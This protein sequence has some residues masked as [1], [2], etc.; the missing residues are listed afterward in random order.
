VNDETVVYP[1]LYRY[2]FV[3]ALALGGPTDWGQRRMLMLMTAMADHWSLVMPDPLLFGHL[4][5]IRVNTVR[6]W[7][8]KFHE[9]Q[10]LSDVEDSDLCLIH[11]P[12]GS[13]AYERISGKFEWHQRFHAPLGGFS[14]GVTTYVKPPRSDEPIPLTA[15]ALQLAVDSVGRTKEG[16]FAYIAFVQHALIEQP[17][18]EEDAGRDKYLGDY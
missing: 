11:I 6:D 17:Q 9:D 4:F 15:R 10:W 1:H 7:I 16:Q 8:Y 18:S 13:E 12:Q 14:R 3:T 2:D 5:N